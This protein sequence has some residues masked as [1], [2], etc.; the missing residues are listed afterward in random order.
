MMKNEA[1]KYIDAEFLK[2]RIF[3][4]ISRSGLITV[5]TL[6][7]HNVLH[8]IEEAPTID[9]ALQESAHWIEDDYG[10]SRCSRCGSERNE[11]EY[12]T[13][14]CPECGSSMDEGI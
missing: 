8:W 2:K 3:R 12:K 5:A 4:D 14:Y 1:V 11:R 6:A 9:V 7:Y 13:P 10:Y